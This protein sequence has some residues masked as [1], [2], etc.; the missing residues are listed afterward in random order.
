MPSLLPQFLQ[1][2]CWEQDLSRL[3]GDQRSSDDRSEAGAIRA[4]A[5]RKRS[6]RAQR[7]VL[8]PLGMKRLVELE[9]VPRM[10]IES[11][12]QPWMDVGHV[13]QIGATALLAMEI[14]NMRNDLPAGQCAS[15]VLEAVR[16]LEDL[17][18]RVSANALSD[19]D[20]EAIQ[21]KVCRMIDW[22]SQQRNHDVDIASRRLVAA[23]DRIRREAMASG[24][25]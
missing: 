25:K 22:I 19:A 10:C 5:V 13:Y 14:A 17:H 24:G 6:R 16:Q 23:H 1:R 8:L 7:P 2:A 20:G 9:L 12:G 3:L 21:R 15:Q 18:E 4:R 11:I